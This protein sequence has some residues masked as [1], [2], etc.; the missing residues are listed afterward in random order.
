[1]QYGSREADPPRPAF[2]TGLAVESV[3]DPCA[4]EKQEQAHAESCP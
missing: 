2:T 4:I 1:M 3:E